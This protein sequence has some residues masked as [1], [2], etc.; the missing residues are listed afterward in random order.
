MERGPPLS[1]ALLPNSGTPG[2]GKQNRSSFFSGRIWKF[3][4]GIVLLGMQ[5]VL[6]CS[7]IGA[8]RQ[9]LSVYFFRKNFYFYFQF[10]ALEGVGDSEAVRG[11]V[12][13]LF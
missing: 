1:P 13:D 10:Q 5:F 3:A 6:K 7:P 4:S 9:S 12:E 8:F 2:S 11:A